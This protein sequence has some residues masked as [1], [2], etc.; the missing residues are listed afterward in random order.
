MT[1]TFENFDVEILKHPLAY[2]YVVHSP[3]AKK[4]EDCYECLHAHDSKWPTKEYNR[5]LKIPPE[6]WPAHGGKLHVCTYIT[7]GMT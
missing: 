1:C 3:K 5:C 6:K 4:D 2:K 7:V